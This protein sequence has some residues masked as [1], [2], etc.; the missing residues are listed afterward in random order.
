MAT[1]PSDQGYTKTLPRH[2]RP[3]F[4]AI[5]V[6]SGSSQAEMMDEGTDISDILRSDLENNDNSEWNIE[7]KESDRAL[8]MR[9]TDFKKL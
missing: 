5:E 4:T 3:H 1:F 9:M 8:M 7:S 2:N 6:T